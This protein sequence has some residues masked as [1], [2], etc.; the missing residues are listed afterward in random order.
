MSLND[1]QSIWNI[2]QQPCCRRHRA[3]CQG[4]QI[5]K[6]S[7]FLE[8]GQTAYVMDRETL[9]MLLLREKIRRQ[10]RGIPANTVQPDG[11]LGTDGGGG[12]GA[13]RKTGPCC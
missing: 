9:N 4:P 8:L 2:G 5:L 11:V 6:V 3:L 7:D 1:D 10:L 13:P 12:N